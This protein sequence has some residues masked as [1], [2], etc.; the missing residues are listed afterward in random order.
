MPP[1]LRVRAATD[2]R[3]DAAGKAETNETEWA[4]TCNSGEACRRYTAIELERF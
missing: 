1:A 4:F 3:R 2:D